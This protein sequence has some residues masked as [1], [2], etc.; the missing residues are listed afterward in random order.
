M[1]KQGFLFALLLTTTGLLAQKPIEIKLWP[2]GAPNTNDL[3]GEESWLGVTHVSNVTQPTLTIYRPQAPNGV[4]IIMCPGGGY[5]RLAFAHEGSDLAPWFNAQGITYAVLK[6]RLPNG[7]C[8]VPIS[9]AEQAIRI[10]R[11]H[12][13]EWGINP[14]SIGIMGASAGGHLASTLATHYSSNETRPDFQIL[15]YPVITMDKSYTHMGSHDNLIG[16]DASAEQEKKFSNE[17]QVNDRTPKAFIALSSD[18]KTVPVANGV[19]YYLS[20]VSHH[21]P[22]SLHTYPIGGHGWGFRDDFIYK[23]Q[24]TGE[25]EKWLQEEVIPYSTSNQSPV[26]RKALNF[27]NIPYVAST[28]EVN[29]EEKL[30]VNLQEVD[31]TTLV[32]Y[33][34]AQ[35]M[36]GDFT[37]NLLRI[38]YR[39]G[40]IDG[41]TSRLHYIADWINNGVRQGIVEDVTAANSPDTEKLSLSYMSQH[42]QLYKSLK[43][44]PE[45]VKRMAQYEKALTGKIIHYLPKTKLK[46]EGFSWIKD[47]DIIAM[48][49]NIQG[50]DVSHMGIAVYKSGKLH[51]L[52]ASSVD[53]KVEISSAPLN[54]MLMKSKSN[55]GIR[56]LRLVV[57]D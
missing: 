5:A 56:V 42:P 3:T 34:L 50:L 52:N 21:I 1:K 45:N 25:L 55:T 26:L 38:R 39:N 8:D 18:D 35:A 49:T 7:H 10:I 23:R 12:S 47:G 53:K 17:L 40:K 31:C 27:I 4:A 36:K 48:C 57:N 16:K 54:E 51:L 30:V 37:T 2:E 41:Y 14:Q 28:L 20:L 6:Y 19:N 43:D 24:W 32:E 11:K 9:D 13:S 15:L 22:A 33:A 29:D 46:A 44:S